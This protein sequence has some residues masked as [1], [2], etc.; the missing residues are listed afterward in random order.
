MNAGNPS[1]FLIRSTPANIN[2]ELFLVGLLNSKFMLIHDLKGS[3]TSF[4]CDKEVGKNLH[5]VM[6]GLRLDESIA[7]EEFLNPV[8]LVVYNQHSR[9][10]YDRKEE[11]PIFDDI[12]DVLGA[13]H[14]YACVCFIP[15]TPNDITLIKARVED[16]LSRKETRQT[17]SRG[18]K[19][20]AASST[21]SVQ[22]ELYYDSE[23]R[24][25]FL[26]ILGMLDEIV[27]LNYTA[28]KVVIII[29]DDWA[30]RQYIQ[31]KIFVMEEIKIPKTGVAEIYRNM[32]GL[33]SIPMTPSKSYPLLKFSGNVY[34]E[35]PMQL[36]SVPSKGGEVLLGT[37]LGNAVVQSSMP[38]MIRQNTLNLGA[39]ITGLPGN[40]K[41]RAAMSIFS[42]VK[43]TCPKVRMAVISPTSEWNNLGS[44]NGLYVIKLY[45]SRVPINFF[46]CDSG[47]K[48]E[49]FYEDLAMLVASATNA[50]PYTNSI[51]KCLLAAFRN[52]YSKNGKPDPT[53]LY[54]EIEESIIEQ[55][56]KRTNTGIKYT[57]HGENIRA[58]LEFLRLMLFRPEFTV[59]EGINFETLLSNGVIF[60]LSNVSNSMKPFFYALILNQI[61][62][63]AG[64]LDDSGDA[65]LRMLIGIEEAQMLFS[66]DE[67]SATTKDLRQRIQDFRKKGVGI[68]L[69]TH[70]ITDININIRRLCQTKIYF[71]Q[72]TDVIR[73][74][75]SD[76][77]FERI[78]EDN[79]ASRMKT[80]SQLEF[81]LNYID[82]QDGRR[83]VAGPIFLRSAH[84]D[85]P[86]AP[87]GR[88]TDY[89]WD[90]KARTI[91]MRISVKA[92]DGK[93]VP[94]T[95]VDIF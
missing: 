88:S 28:Y 64:S 69:L 39:I 5:S 23:E 33:E 42:Q 40:G 85:E 57:K 16:A 21:E 38:I 89:G 51:E 92:A 37:I 55:H 78:S 4:I 14:S 47:I 8:G 94:G 41:T 56:G 87:E 10:P 32:D 54:E 67:I 83:R 70:S 82:A 62:C 35:F 49:K 52:V 61:Y 60:D 72:G 26:S 81:A 66:D 22:T 91:Q 74:A 50:G 71:R 65:E 58:G 68:V 31:S 9:S 1:K 80:L 84:L 44:A 75:I 73:Y 59:T 18:S 36:P 3:T 11:K 27:L 25:T 86:R 2:Y 13:S 17:R 63:S 95:K 76:L 30:A 6:P 34:K 12:Y 19:T 15:S 90:C 43:G 48:I 7:D 29:E 45:D 53:E 79:A 46:K 77:G 20:M 93:P 24:S